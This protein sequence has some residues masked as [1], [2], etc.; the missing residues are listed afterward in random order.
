MNKQIS[1]L[2]VI[3]LSLM[4]ITIAN[5]QAATDKIEIRGEVSQI[6]TGGPTTTFTVNSWDAKNFAGFW[7]DIN[8][9]KKTENLDILKFKDNR[10]IEKGDLVYSTGRASQ[11]YKVFKEKGKTIDNGLNSDLVKTGSGGYYAL[12]GWMAE[13]YVAINGKNNKLSK[14]VLNQAD[15]KTLQIGET[16]NLGEGYTLTAQSID[17]KATP[18]QAWFILSKDGVKLDDKVSSQG[19]VY[20]YSIKSLTGETD[21]PIFVT[22]VDSVFS[23]TN[24]DMAQLKYTW[25]ISDKVTEIKSGDKF[26][27][28]EVD[29][30]QPLN[31]TND[32]S[33]SLSRD[34]TVN[35]AGNIKFK[36]ADSEDND[37][38]FYPKI[39]Y[40]VGGATTTSIGNE[41]PIP[42]VTSNQTS[43][44]ITTTVPPPI[45]TTVVPLPT[46]TMPVKSV[47]M[48]KK[49]DTPGFEAIVA[50]V[51][52]ISIVYIVL[53]QKK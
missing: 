19:D 24:S 18:R 35:I 10:T 33:I 17:A 45:T 12:V 53:R 44:P 50:I 6:I 26:G 9:N 28:F 49:K 48:D 42:T 51:S 47:S 13:K 36:I 43:V 3:L 31:L 34:S 41:T 23:G 2:L 15:T 20:T 8:G 27:V 37:V 11:K 52:L 29:S 1:I 25:L 14:L 30:L 38:R 21:V 7:Y 46:E 39:D 4:A 5:V 40:D 22:Y 16:W 32:V